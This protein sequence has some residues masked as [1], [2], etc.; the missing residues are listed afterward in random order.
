MSE[1]DDRRAQLGA[2]ALVALVVLVLGFG[3][4]IGAVFERDRDADS[5][6][7]AATVPTG[8][9]RGA[10]RADVTPATTTAAGTASARRVTAAP[11]TTTGAPDD[12]GHGA[13]TTTTVAPTTS[14]TTAPA[15]PTTTP[16]TAP[17]VAASCGVLS[18]MLDPLLG[19]ISAAHL[20]TS[21]G[22]QVADAA[23]VDDYVLAHTSLI[24]AILA[25][26][27][28]LLLDLD[29]NSPLWTHLRAAHL[30]SSLGQQ[31]AD[32]LAVDDYVLAH[33]VLVDD[34]LLA[35]SSSC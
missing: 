4:G 17:P 5:A 14:T 18:A 9:G 30:E 22:Q 16:T 2:A 10:V 31:L 11:S 33:T 32:L 27:L 13:T 21:V 19:H 24:D 8:P 26:L 3:A 23:D 1:T 28:N 25:P 35:G 34:M 7:P 20:E 12:H 15:V 29:G 6:T